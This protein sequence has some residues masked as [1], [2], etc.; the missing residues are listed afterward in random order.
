MSN[1]DRAVTE[2]RLFLSSAWGGGGVWE[3]LVPRC[4]GLPGVSSSSGIGLLTAR[5]SSQIHTDTSLKEGSFVF[6]T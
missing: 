2:C 6:P 1:F 5:R 4:V 3:G